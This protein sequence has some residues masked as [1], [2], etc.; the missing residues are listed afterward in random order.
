MINRAAILWVALIGWQLS[1][2]LAASAVLW[3]GV[4]SSPP[5]NIQIPLDD[6]VVLHSSRLVYLLCGAAIAWG[7]TS[8]LA[9]DRLAIFLATIVPAILITADRTVYSFAEWALQFGVM[10]YMLDWWIVRRESETYTLAVCVACHAVGVIVLFPICQFALLGQSTPMA[11]EAGGELL[12][13]AL[14]IL[15]SV[16][17][18]AGA[19]LRV[20]V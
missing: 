10:V 18:I 2:G 7:I 11:C 6:G 9:R 15:G 16:A 5:G 19:M 8:H 13:V 3:L 20:R 14:P 17:L 4:P 1:P 12:I